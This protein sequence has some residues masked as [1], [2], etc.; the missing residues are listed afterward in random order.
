[1]RVTKY[2]RAILATR[3]E[4]SR[5][6]KAGYLYNEIDWRLHRG[7]LTRATITDVKIAVHGKGVWYKIE[8]PV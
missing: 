8:E 2:T 5:M 4:R 3:R 7:A 1:M 6:A